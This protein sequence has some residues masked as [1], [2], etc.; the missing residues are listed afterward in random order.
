MKTL[1]ELFLDELADMYDAERR[2]VKAL[3]KIAK[4]A[5]C[6]KLKAAIQAHLVETKGHVTKIEQT[7]KSFNEKSR[8]KTCQATV[9]ILK[10]GDEIASEN[11]GDLTINAALILAAQKVEHYEIASYGCLHA[12]AGLLGNKQAASLLEKILDEEKAAND[13]LTKLALA[14][15]NKEALCECDEEESTD[16]V[17]DK[18]PAN[19]RRG[20]RPV[21]LGRKRTTSL[22]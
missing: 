19:L 21:R 12:W 5:T 11:K 18:R 10:E 2:I 3:P 14:T 9:G 20:I 22:I 15:S 17:V 13:T 7:F 6:P 8:G 1:K 16:E 4:A